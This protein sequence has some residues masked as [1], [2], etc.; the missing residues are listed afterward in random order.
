M[1]T[2][3]NKDFLETFKTRFLAISISNTLWSN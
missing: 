1:E 2:Q 3:N